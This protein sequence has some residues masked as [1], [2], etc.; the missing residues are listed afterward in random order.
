MCLA[1]GCEHDLQSLYAQETPAEVVWGR[2]SADDC[3]RC[4]LP[5]CP[6]EAAE[7]EKSAAC[8]AQV[9]CLESC[10]TPECA[11]QCLRDGEAEELSCWR[12]TCFDT[13]WMER[14]WV[15]NTEVL[16]GGRL[17]ADCATC[18]DR[19]CQQVMT[20]CLN[21][22]CVEELGCYSS[23]KD[24]PC[25]HR[26]LDR[27]EGD[28]AL[29]CLRGKCFD[30][31]DIGQHLECVGAYAD[32]LDVTKPVTVDLVLAD[33]FLATPAA[34]VTVEQCTESALKC[35]SSSP[36]QTT[37]E[38]GHASFTF[39]PTTER[40]TGAAV[41]FR[42]NGEDSPAPPTP[43]DYNVAVPARYYTPFPFS[44]NQTLH[45]PTI[46]LDS[47][48]QLYMASEGGD[49]LADRGIISAVVR[50]CQTDEAPLLQ[51]K[52]AEGDEHTQVIYQ[53]G[54][55]LDGTFHETDTTGHVLIL[56]VPILETDPPGVVT[57]QAYA[58]DGK[59]LVAQRT[60]GVQPYSVT[61]VWLNP[62][63]KQ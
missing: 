32:P 12:E 5:S 34:G 51:V 57:L 15:D 33:F 4:V 46:S 31:C 22:S 19:E 38:N 30:Q 2:G 37:D 48:M 9:A 10:S 13:C 18:F 24:P 44:G 3:Q 45:L 27:T 35:V 21:A 25:M 20:T 28:Q 63:Q 56:N 11:A 55:R 14:N 36:N 29:E 1:I 8:R 23:C 49:L 39:L 43:P 50:D 7:C 54:S 16:L 59:D 52:L 58:N 42:V 53:R 62:R 60:V 41:F 6:A 47:A 40:G 26:C 17:S 61:V